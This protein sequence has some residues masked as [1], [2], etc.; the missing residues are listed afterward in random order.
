MVLYEI[1]KSHCAFAKIP[2]AGLVAAPPPKLRMV[3]PVDKLFPPT[4]L[5]LSPKLNGLVAA[6]PT[7]TIPALQF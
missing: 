5:A 3:F 7:K 2:V 6:K 1:F 4:S